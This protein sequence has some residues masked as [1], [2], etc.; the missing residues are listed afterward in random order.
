[1]KTV[2]VVYCAQSNWQRSIAGTNAVI[3]LLTGVA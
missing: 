2:S 1:V 3:V